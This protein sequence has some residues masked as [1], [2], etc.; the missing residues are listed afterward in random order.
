[1]PLNMANPKANHFGHTRSADAG[2]PN[3][4][5]QYPGHVPLGGGAA[6]QSPA[7]QDNPFQQQ[8]AETPNM[9][10]FSFSDN[11]FEMLM[12]QMLSGFSGG[13]GPTGPMSSMYS[14]QNSGR[15]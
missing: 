14:N 6:G 8:S 15:I 12:R 7:A 3:N 11:N 13:T 9:R 1:M 4:G 2:H 10:D 5:Q